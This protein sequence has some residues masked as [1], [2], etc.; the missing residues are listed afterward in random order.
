MKMNQVGFISQYCIVMAMIVDKSL[1][2]Q[3]NYTDFGLI[4]L[5]VCAFYYHFKLDI[6]EL[7]DLGETS[8]IRKYLTSSGTAYPAEMLGEENLDLLGGWITALFDTNGISDELM[9]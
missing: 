7:G 5:L 3:D 6:F 4:L 8:F 2:F 9:K 1:D